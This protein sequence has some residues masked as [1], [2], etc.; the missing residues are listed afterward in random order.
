MDKA[1]ALRVLFK[2]ADLFKANLADRNLLFLYLDD[3][4]DIRII[5]TQ[6]PVSGFMHLTGVKYCGKKISAHTFF[7]KCIKRRL[8][9]NEFDLASDGTTRLKLEVLPILLSKNLSASMIGEFS[10]RAPL[11]ITDKLIGGVKGC[12]GFVYDQ[13][14]GCYVPNTVLNLDIRTY[15]IEPK[16][17]IGVFRKM[18]NEDRYSEVV[19]RAKMVNVS[20]VSFPERYGYLRSLLYPDMTV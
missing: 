9:I 15:L 3:R 13:R 12:M 19:Y 20:I 1:D 14:L 6:F 4:H 8:K 11:L 16:R 17:V 18:I 7:D 10:G 5:E 2:C